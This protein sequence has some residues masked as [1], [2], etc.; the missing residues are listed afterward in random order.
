MPLY[1]YVCES[2]STEFEKLM[3][4][5]DPKPPCP[6]CGATDVKKMVSAAAFSLKGGGWY[7]DGYSKPSGGDA[8]STPKSDSKSTSKSAPK[9]SGGGDS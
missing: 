7:K 2:C 3:R 1:E 8:K 6:E 4:M 9:S 5:S